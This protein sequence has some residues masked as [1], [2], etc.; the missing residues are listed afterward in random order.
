[1]TLLRDAAPQ[2][3]PAATLKGKKND[4]N[5]EDDPNCILPVCFSRDLEYL[6]LCHPHLPPKPV[7]TKVIVGSQRLELNQFSVSSPPGLVN[8]Q[9]N[10]A[11]GRVQD[12]RD[13]TSPKIR[14]L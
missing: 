7:V 10:K 14:C 9:T 1:M 3:Q 5:Q 4:F 2:D 8:K 12:H 13:Q 11:S 6:V